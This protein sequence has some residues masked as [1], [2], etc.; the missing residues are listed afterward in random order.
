MGAFPKAS[1]IVVEKGNLTD[2]M[3]SVVR[4][5]KIPCVVRV[6]NICS[7]LRD[8]QE[9]TVDASKGI[10]YEGIVEELF[11]AMETDVLPVE[12]NIRETE[13][14]NILKKNIKIYFPFVS[15]RSQDTGI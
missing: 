9:I 7:I 15:N 8:G 12:I 1:A 6:E 3:S 14:Y 5:F 13:S 11:D 10:I 4:E 2:H